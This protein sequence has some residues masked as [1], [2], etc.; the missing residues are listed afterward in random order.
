[1]RRMT[2]LITPTPRLKIIRATQ[3]LTVKAS[4]ELGRSVAVEVRGPETIRGHVPARTE[5]KKVNEGGV[6]VARSGG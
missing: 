1:M 5:P 4:E 3:A 2:P 6:G